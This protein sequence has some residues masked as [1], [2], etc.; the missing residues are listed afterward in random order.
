MLEAYIVFI[1]GLFV[2]GI[3]FGTLCGAAVG[4]IVIGSGLMISSAIIGMTKYLHG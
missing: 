1:I 4:W 3:S 2:I